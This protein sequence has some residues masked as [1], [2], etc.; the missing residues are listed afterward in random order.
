MK[1]RVVQRIHSGRRRCDRPEL[2]QSRP[3]PPLVL[4]LTKVVTRTLTLFLP[5]LSLLMRI[6]QEPRERRTTQVRG[7]IPPAP[8]PCPSNCLFTAKRRHAHTFFEYAS[9]GSTTGGDGKRSSMRTCPDV[10]AQP[11]RHMVYES[12]HSVVAAL[13][14]P[15]TSEE[16]AMPFLSGKVSPYTKTA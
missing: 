9:E 3:R 4:L 13:E 16:P 8:P 6:R 11:R 1:D 5:C 2:I 10:G 15:P 12:R 14:G 7:L